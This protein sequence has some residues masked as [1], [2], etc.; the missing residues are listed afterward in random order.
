MDRRGT[1]VYLQET[2]LVIHFLAQNMGR[3]IAPYIPLTLWV[4]NH[5]SQL[6]GFMFVFCA[7]YDFVFVVFICFYVGFLRPAVV[8][9][10]SDVI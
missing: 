8:Y 7:P 9:I 10:Y 5:S 2:E 4:S 3:Y 6:L 1:Y